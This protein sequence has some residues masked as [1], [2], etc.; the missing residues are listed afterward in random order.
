MYEP[1]S[2][3]SPQ[4]NKESIIRLSKEAL[5]LDLYYDI[6]LA[7][8]D[9]LVSRL[10]FNPPAYIR[11]GLV[12]SYPYGLVG[13]FELSNAKSAGQNWTGTRRQNRQGWRVMLKVLAGIHHKWRFPPFVHYHLK[14][15]PGFHNFLVICVGVMECVDDLCVRIGAG[16]E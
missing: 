3:S 7:N 10:F 14:N 2:L 15:A 11:I 13:L 4:D 8:Y 5:K 6:S 1:F 12:F 16:S 9:V